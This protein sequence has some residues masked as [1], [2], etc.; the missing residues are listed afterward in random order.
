[1]YIKTSHE[2]TDITAL[3]E[4]HSLM[5]HHT[6]DKIMIVTNYIECT[7]LHSYIAND[8]MIYHHHIIMYHS[9]YL[10]SDNTFLIPLAISKVDR[11][12]RV[13]YLLFLLFLLLLL[14]MLFFA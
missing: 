1:M 14:L 4:A 7:P 6:R 3:L 12:I 10:F 8:I 2:P 13:D 11:L 5:Y 9:S